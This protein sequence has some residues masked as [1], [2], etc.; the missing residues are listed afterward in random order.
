MFQ[1]LVEE[2]LKQSILKRLKIA[3]GLRC[4]RAE[5]PFRAGASESDDE[6]GMHWQHGAAPKLEACVFESSW[7]S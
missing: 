6:A 4:F 2:P 1:E 7:A 3:T 5:G